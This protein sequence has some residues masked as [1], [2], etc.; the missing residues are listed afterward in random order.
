MSSS[1][2]CNWLSCDVMMGMQWNGTGPDKFHE[3]IASYYKFRASVELLYICV[4]VSSS[5]SPCPDFGTDPTHL[6]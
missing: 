1:R 5:S 4:C 2:P 6:I 3:L